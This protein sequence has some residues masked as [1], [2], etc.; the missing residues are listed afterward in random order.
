MVPFINK[1]VCARGAE[2]P[3]APL[4][5]V[6]GLQDLQLGVGDLLT[7]QLGDPVSLLHHK[8]G[9]AVVEHHNTDIAPVVLVHHPSPDVDVVFPGE[10]RP[11][12]HTAVGAARDADLEVS[13]HET[14]A[15]CW[16]G[17]ILHRE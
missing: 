14:F 6:Q 15:S 16:Y 13:L 10:A 2:A 7:D 3:L 4:R 9:V 12:S 8:L 5:V 17:G 11:R 1:S